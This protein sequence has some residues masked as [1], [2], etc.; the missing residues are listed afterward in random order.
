MI[1]GIVN[2]DREPVILLEFSGTNGVTETVEVVVDTGYNG[3]VTVTPEINDRLKL[4]FK[5]T[6]FY[7]LGDG[8]VAE[9][10]IHIVT[11]LWDGQKRDVDAT[12]TE[13]GSLLG[14]SLLD[15]C[16]LFIDGRIG[17]EVRIA[18]RSPQP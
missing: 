17:G 13:G 7:E 15:D 10:P 3:T 18:L 8:V 6:R 5:E 2:E 16:T 1:T 11:I 14:M 9:L 4:P 12:V